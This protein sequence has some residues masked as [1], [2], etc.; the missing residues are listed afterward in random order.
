MNTNTTNTLLVPTQGGRRFRRLTRLTAWL[1]ATAIGVGGFSLA[2]TWMSAQDAYAADGTINWQVAISQLERDWLYE[3][4]TG[5]IRVISNPETDNTPASNQFELAKGNGTDGNMSDDE[6]RKLA[7]G[8]D[9]TQPGR[10]LVIWAWEAGRTTGCRAG[11]NAVK[12]LTPGSNTAKE[13]CIPANT[14]GGQ[15]GWWSGGAV[16][17]GSGQ[18]IFT[19]TVLTTI[20]NNG[21]GNARYQICTPPSAGNEMSCR[22]SGAIAPKTPGDWLG[23]SSY[24][25]WHPGAGM[26]IDAEGSFYQ[27]YIQDAEKWLVKITPGAAGA[28]WYFEKVLRLVNNG[29]DSN[30][31]YM[32]GLSLAWAPGGLYTTGWVQVGE[33]P[34]VRIDT[35]TGVASFTGWNI[36]S[37]GFLSSAATPKLVRGNVW[38][39]ADGDGQISDDEKTQPVV[40]AEIELYKSNSSRAVATTT[41]NESGS[42]R[43]LVGDWDAD[44]KVVWNVRVKQPVINGVNASQT[45]A[46]G[47]SQK[48]EAATGSIVP[49]SIDVVTPRCSGTVQP[50]GY[51]GPCV[52]SRLDGIDPSTGV[53]ND[54]VFT[55]TGANIVTQIA[56]LTDEEV[57]VA[58]FGLST[59]ASY[60]DAPN[61]YLTTRSVSGPMAFPKVSGG[62]LYLGA[63]PGWYADGNPVA[64]A[65]YHASDDGI[66]VRDSGAA[67][68]PW[69]PL[70]D[71]ILAVGRTYDLRAKL[72][73]ASQASGFVKGWIAPLGG[74]GTAGTTFTNLVL[75][76]S[77]SN[78]TPDGSG[79]VYGQYTVPT[80]LPSGGLQQTFFRARAGLNPTT[81]H[82]WTGPSLNT[83][84]QPARNNA[85][86]NSRPWLAV[87]EVEDFGLG[88]ATGTVKLEARTLGGVGSKFDYQLTNV[89]STLPS[90]NTASV[91]TTADGNWTASGRAHAFSATNSPVVINA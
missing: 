6:M 86:W 19:P 31:W 80:Q 53:T 11:F 84:E 64:R 14:Y 91:T 69:V 61:S 36:P 1:V 18:I 78:A 43:F 48:V 73:G 33:A 17:R 15:D 66:E 34:T 54:N 2:Q 89:S 7:V 37:N 83:T 23:T 28:T 26:A 70:Q 38:V 59:V 60:G 12:R 50:S 21:T 13:F 41:T 56:A 32:V 47:Y 4:T 79:Y 40:G 75:G 68:S 77:A 76:T 39:D 25:D 51:A 10:P 87:G 57:A 65:D 67:S 74:G 9:Y 46:A 90:Y 35:M 42:Y 71:Q 49:G 82:A 81:A 29:L 45:Y 22:L 52:G 62:E 8:P 55:E 27:V 58:D 44:G 63:A 72:T 85:A 5:H 24:F 20:R 88:V 30:S 16:V 3:A